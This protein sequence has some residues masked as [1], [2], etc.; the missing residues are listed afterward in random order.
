MVMNMFNK[1]E[2]E[3]LADQNRSDLAL[4]IEISKLLFNVDNEKDIVFSKLSNGKI[5]KAIYI[6]K[7][8]TKALCL[9]RDNSISVP[10]VVMTKSQKDTFDLAMKNLN[11]SS[12]IKSQEFVGNLYKELQR[13]SIS[14]ED[15]EFFLGV[16]G[17]QYAMILEHPSLIEVV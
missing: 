10:G 16:T 2:K 9:Q 1:R 11:S 12:D 15:Y 8:M 17:Y 5:N 14:D 7:E 13:V 4:K 6:L 3:V